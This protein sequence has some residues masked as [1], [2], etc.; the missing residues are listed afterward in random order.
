MLLQAFY[1]T[2]VKINFGAYPY[3]Y[4]TPFL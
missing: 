2:F 4:L 3:S 1:F